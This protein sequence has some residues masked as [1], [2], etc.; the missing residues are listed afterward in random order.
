MQPLP[1]YDPHSRRISRREFLKLSGASLLGFVLPPVTGL[2][3]L[4]LGQQG[5]VIDNEISVHEKPEPDSPIVKRY[6]KDMVFPISEVTIGGPEPAHNRVW[7]MI[8]DEGYAHSGGI[9]PVRTILNM[10]TLTIPQEGMLVEVTVPY[11]DAHYGPGRNIPVGYRYYYE[12]THWVIGAKEGVGGEVWYHILEDKWEIEYYA[13]AA[14]FRVI[15]SEE[16]APL[17]SDLPSEAKR[18]EVRTDEQVVI[19]YEWEKP[20]FMTLTATGAKFSNGNF[21]TPGGRHSTFHKRPSRH[22][23]AGNLALNGYDLPGVPWIC[24]FTESGV[25]FHGT[26]W[27]NNYGRPRSHGCINLSPSAAK[28]VYRWTDPYVPPGMQDVYENFGTTV[29]VVGERTQ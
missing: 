6:W 20:V 13:P 15:P 17:S 12:T 25:S 7:Y 27:H 21:Y 11:T 3:T 28:W 2:D 24:Y 18:L 23:A 5:R 22:M 4:L 16:L 19:A 8:R 1:F 9:Q 14:H 26:Y 10:P 29:D